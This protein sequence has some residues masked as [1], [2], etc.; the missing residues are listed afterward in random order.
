MSDTGETPTPKPVV[1]VGGGFGS[2]RAPAPGEPHYAMFGKLR[3]EKLGDGVYQF[4]GTPTVRAGSPSGG[5]AVPMVAHMNP[6]NASEVISTDIYAPVEFASPNSPGEVSA[7][8]A[9]EP[10]DKFYFDWVCD[11]GAITRSGELVG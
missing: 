10:G 1:T 8:V 7:V 2:L 4:R 3:E 9:A 11:N 6:E 5:R